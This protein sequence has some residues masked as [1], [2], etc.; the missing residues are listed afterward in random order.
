LERLFFPHPLRQ[1]DLD[2]A[3]AEEVRVLGVEVFEA[4]STLRNPV[5]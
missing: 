3:V 2:T 1:E 5:T 4:Q